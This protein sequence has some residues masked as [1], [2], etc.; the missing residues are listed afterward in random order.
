MKRKRSNTRGRA[1]KMAEAALLAALAQQEL[2]AMRSLENA[3][4]ALDQGGL[5]QV[6]NSNENGRNVR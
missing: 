1:S 4:Q 3:M 6:G 2:E 5:D